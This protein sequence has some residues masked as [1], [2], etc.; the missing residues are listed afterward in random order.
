M[1]HWTQAVGAGET[2]CALGKKPASPPPPPPPHVLTL[3]KPGGD[4]HWGLCFFN[5]IMG[6]S[7]FLN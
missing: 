4:R 5:A 2:T 3:H 7:L 6:Y 1:E